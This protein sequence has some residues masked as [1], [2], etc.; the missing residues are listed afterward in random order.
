M[1]IWMRAF[2]KLIKLLFIAKLRNFSLLKLNC[3]IQTNS[4]KVA[5]KV[6]TTFYEYLFFFFLFDDLE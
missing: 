1:I 2:S 3:M 4:C 5:E 6:L